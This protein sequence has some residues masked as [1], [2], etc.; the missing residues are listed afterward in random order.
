MEAHGQ[1]VVPAEE[2]NREAY[3]VTLHREKHKAGEA[4]HAS[5]PSKTHPQ[6]A[7]PSR[8]S[9]EALGPRMK[10]DSIH[11]FLLSNSTFSFS[12]SPQGRG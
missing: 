7:L 12:L 8:W 9:H 4:A 10:P 11:A 2:E 1:S 3:K 6:A 5:H